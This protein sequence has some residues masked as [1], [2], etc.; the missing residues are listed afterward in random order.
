MLLCDLDGDAYHDTFLCHEHLLHSFNSTTSSDIYLYMASLCFE[1][2]ESAVTKEQRACA[3]QLS[4]GIL[5]GMGSK[6]NM[7]KKLTKFTGRS[8]T[9]TEAQ[10]LIKKWN[11]K[12]NNNNNRKL[13]PD[14]ERSLLIVGCW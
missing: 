14:S 2:D 6:D 9:E 12:V 7:A 13:H 8:Y 4:L 3:K 1:C 5:Y 10:A 11:E